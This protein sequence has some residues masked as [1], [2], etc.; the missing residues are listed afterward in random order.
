M[1]LQTVTDRTIFMTLSGSHAYG[2]NTP[3]SDEDYRGVCVPTKEYLFGT[4]RFDQQ[5]Y[6][7]EDK[8]VYDIP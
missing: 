8:V 5:E 3:E 1:N 6:P 4:K 2:L 7:N